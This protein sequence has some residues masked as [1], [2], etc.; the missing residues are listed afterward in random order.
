MNNKGTDQHLQMMQADLGLC[1]H[2]QNA[3]FHQMQLIKSKVTF[4]PY[5]KI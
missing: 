1:S 4:V 3:D 2:M 5:K